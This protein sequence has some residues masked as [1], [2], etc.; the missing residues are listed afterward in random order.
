MIDM[1]NLKQL[2][3]KIG[4][5]FNDKDYLIEALCHPTYL[6]EN[7][8]FK[9]QFGLV[10]GH[11]Q[12]LEHLGDSILGLIIA[13][14]LYWNHPGREGELTK[15]KTHFANGSKAAEI[16]DTIGLEKFLIVGVGESNNE[17]GREKRIKDSLEALIAAIFLDQSYQGYKKARDFV[18]KFFLYDLD[19]ILDNV[20]TIII[21]DNPIGHL[22]E[23][24]QA[25]GFEV[26]KYEITKIEG[27]DHDPT[28]L[29]NVYVNSEKI[30]EASGKKKDVKKN[31][32][33]NAIKSEFIKNLQS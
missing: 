14:K 9:N 1:E 28:F 19:N 16:S 6:E 20:D 32:A 10:D 15:I 21:E 13:E 12:R 2:E 5:D 33:I 31:A 11:N 22:Q 4:I 27:P 25:A 26:P 18:N 29:Y 23:I 17:S 24:V 30:A 7:P 8:G 3:E